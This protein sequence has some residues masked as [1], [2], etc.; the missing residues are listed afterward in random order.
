MNIDARILNKILINQIQELIKMIIHHD[1][2]GFIP[3]MQ[4]WFNLW[5]FIKE[6]HYTNK[7]KENKP[8][9]HFIR[10]LKNIWQSPTPLP[11]KSL[12][13]IRNS[14]P[15]DKYSKNNIKQTSSQHQTK[16]RET[17]SNPTKIRD[18]I[19]LSTLSLPVQYSTQCSSQRN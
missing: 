8:R 16:W 17:W 11:D 1:Q 6:I 3:G 14:M 4:G 19:R 2:V 15:I 5:K 9:D 18:K 7:F 13:K 12:G 10:W